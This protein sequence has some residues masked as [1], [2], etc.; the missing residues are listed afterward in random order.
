M[1]C[2]CE[3]GLDIESDRIRTDFLCHDVTH[4][5]IT[6]DSSLSCC[7][8]CLAYDCKRAESGGIEGKKERLKKNNPKKPTLTKVKLITPS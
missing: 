4:Q 7:L 1:A 3:K 8:I 6:T 2:F 5:N